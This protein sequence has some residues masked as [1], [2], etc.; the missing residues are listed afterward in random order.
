MLEPS[1]MGFNIAMAHWKLHCAIAMVNHAI[2]FQGK[3]K[4][5]N[6][7]RGLKKLKEEI[8]T[9]IWKGGAFLQLKWNNTST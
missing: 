8:I 4:L 5:H 2:P 6:L 9:L 3:W 1:S 7:W